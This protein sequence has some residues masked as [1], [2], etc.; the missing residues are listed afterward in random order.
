MKEIHGKHKK[1]LQQVNEKHETALKQLEE[2]YENIQ[3]L[4]AEL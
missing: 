1:S 3:S 4:K 2:Q